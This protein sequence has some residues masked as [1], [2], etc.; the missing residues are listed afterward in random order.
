MESSPILH[1][2][3][4][5]QRAAVVSPAPV[6]QVLAPPG[7]GKTKTLTSRVSWLLYHHKYK[8]WN[9]ICLTF[10]I[11]SA[12]EMKERIANQIGEG[13]ESKLILG[14]FHSV[15]LRYLR[16]YGHL[17]G[18]R[19]GFGIA[20]SSDSQAIINRIVKLQKLTLEARAA[21]SRISH[22]K[23]KNISYDGL[24]TKSRQ[25]KAKKSVDQQEF[26]IL[27]EAYQ[28]HLATAN[29]LDYDDILLQCVE[30][31]SQH[32]ECVSNVEAVLIDEFQDTNHVQFD[33]MR[34]FA[35]KNKRV[36]TVGDPDQ[37]IY[38]WRSAEIANLKRMQ[39][40]YPETL[41]LNLE[42][43]YR[44]SCL[45]LEAA[46]E[47]IEQDVARPEK[48]LVPTHCY[49][50][51]PVL[52][53]LFSTATQAQWIVAELKRCIA[54]TGNKLFSFSD[55]AVL[56]RSG[57][58]SRQIETAMGKAG[59][60]Y[61]MVGGLRFF[62]RVEIKILLDYLRVINQPEN[63]EAVS[64]IINTPRRGVGETTIK[65]LLEQASQDSKP[66]WEL[67]KDSV[68][69][70]KSLKLNSKAEKGVETFFDIIM[71]CRKFLLDE[72][73]QVS[74]QELLHRI[75]SRIDFKQFLEKEHPEDHENRWANVEELV[76]QASEYDC[77]SLNEEKDE[78]STL[79]RLDGIDQQTSSASVEALS[80]FLANI[81][82][83]TELQMDDEADENGRPRPKVTLSTIHA[84]KG[85]EWPVVFIP[86]T[87]QGS[88]PHSRAED[89]DEERRL[90]YVAMTRAQVLL[91]LSWPSR[92][93]NGEESTLSSF[94]SEGKIS[95]RFIQKGPS[96]FEIMEATCSILGRQAPSQNA[97][98][99]G[100]QSIDCV[101]DDIVKWP[102]SGERGFG[103]DGDN[104]LGHSYGHESKR[105]KISDE[106][107]VPRLSRSSSAGKV[108]G[109]MA[110]LSEPLVA[111]GFSAQDGFTS[112][113]TY[114]KLHPQI[115]PS[116]N[117]MAQAGK[118]Q[119]QK[120][121]LKGKSRKSGNTVGQSTLLSAW[122][123]SHQQV[124]PL[125]GKSTV[126]TPNYSSKQRFA[127]HENFQQP[128]SSVAMQ[129]GVAYDSSG[130]NPSRQ[131]IHNT[132][133]S[134][135]PDS[136]EPSLPGLHIETERSMQLVPE[137]LAQHR[138]RNGLTL[139]LWRSTGDEEQYN[140]PYIYLSSSPPKPSASGSA[141]REVPAPAKHS[142]AVS[143]PVET[144]HKTTMS[145]LPNKVG[146]TK[147]SY[148][149]GRNLTAWKPS[150]FSVPRIS[151]PGSG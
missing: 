83:S 98:D 136:K 66:L 28:N 64:R 96:M 120:A 42:H 18:L 58:Q 99:Q 26:L 46:Q 51:Y 146:I 114:M 38:G 34:L 59:I 79:P 40:I 144:M 116:T 90:L 108:S 87:F 17:I 45:I 118:F 85:L 135:R 10:T 69:G 80:N 115:E 147:K 102:T 129:D 91:Y 2:L 31:L 41:V 97:I 150:T 68:Q 5:R 130:F 4:S 54:T 141:K 49:G 74:P 52:R 23:A 27:Y 106:A 127:N 137:E 81:A 93:S 107:H 15:C 104:D 13:L 78:M 126:A 36:T 142:L 47:L 35:S 133:P 62:D 117:S 100:V 43:N 12:R 25:Q 48:R 61:R 148:G 39:K 113:T 76:A 110:A 145:S 50:T 75:L 105:R 131:S 111:E 29:L 103:H 67:L 122:N 109:S 140:D 30:L 77:A 149:I 21:R 84:A 70:R 125:A 14:T 72:T 124:E 60:P 63:S 19:K 24:V 3:N 22:N 20:D 55:F 92:S 7:S 95:E 123:K 88:I 37:S 16:H 33:L 86:S 1:G 132:V 73:T 71:K 11:K 53:R 57:Y 82:L 101:E 94:L 151:R 89:H 119:G 143:R 44:S 139:Q 56:I 121:F 6:V 8:P 128:S 65:S 112:A 138:I 134:L 32:P 9:V